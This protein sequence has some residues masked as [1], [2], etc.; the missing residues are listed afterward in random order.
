[1]EIVIEK[2]IT[3]M[4]LVVAI[5]WAFQFL[6]RKIAYLKKYKVQRCLLLPIFRSHISWKL[7]TLIDNAMRASCIA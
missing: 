3:L 5:Y 4:F 6:R 7:Y 2:T 1:M